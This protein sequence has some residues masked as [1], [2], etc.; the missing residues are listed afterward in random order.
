MLK[1]EIKVVF[2]SVYRK[3]LE[4]NKKFFL[5]E[6]IYKEFKELL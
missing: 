2:G 5:E 4:E 6:Y 3:L 1:I